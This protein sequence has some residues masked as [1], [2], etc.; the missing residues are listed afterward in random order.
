MKVMNYHFKLLLVNLTKHSL[1]I[2]IE[3]HLINLGKILK[4]LLELDK[5][6]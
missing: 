4:L 6:A 5:N 3:F 1:F 2:T